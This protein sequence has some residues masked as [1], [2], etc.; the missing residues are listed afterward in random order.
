MQNSKLR[1]KKMVALPHFRK[2]YE[3]SKTRVG[4]SNFK[5]AILLGPLEDSSVQFIYFP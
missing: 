4:D 2:V 5:T 1:I 3:F